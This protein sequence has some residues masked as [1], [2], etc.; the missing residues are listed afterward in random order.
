MEAQQFIEK[1]V[2]ALR[3]RI[4][5]THV[6]SMKVQV[7]K[8]TA[9]RNSAG[10][11]YP[12]RDFM[13]QEASSWLCTTG[14]LHAMRSHPSQNHGSSY[15][16]ARTSVLVKNP[17]ARHHVTPVLAQ[18]NLKVAETTSQDLKEKLAHERA[19]FKVHEKELAAAE[20]KFSGAERGHAAVLKVGLA[21]S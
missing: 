17:L 19:K 3:H 11:V 15:L 8:C 6:A 16:S 21:R 9:I 12:P 4:N 13:L 20:K 14:T 5:A 1:Q 18:A 10:C 7:C 2:E